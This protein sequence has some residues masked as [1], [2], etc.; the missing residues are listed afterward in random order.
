MTA[1]PAAPPAAPSGTREVLALADGVE[2]IGEFEDS[3]F[4]EPPLLARRGDGQ[5]VKLTPLLH[6]VAAACDGRRDAEQV[7]AVVSERS[8]AA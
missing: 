1:T 3:G 5:M 2:L 8:G 6:D 7:A 4:R